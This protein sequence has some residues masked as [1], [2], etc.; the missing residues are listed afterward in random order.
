MKRFS[1]ITL[2]TCRTTAPARV[3]LFAMGSLLALL[4]VDLF[5]EPTLTLTTPELTT[6]HFHSPEYDGYAD[7]IVIEALRRIGYKL[8]VV[9]LPPERSLMMAADGTFDGELIRTP[10]IEIKYPDL[11]RIP[12]PITS[13]E[14]VVYSYHPI[15]LSEGWAALKGKSVAMVIGMKVIE[16]NIPKDAKVTGV[17]SVKQLFTMVENRR[18][19]YSVYVRDIGEDFIKTNQIKGISASKQSIGRIDSYIYLNNKNRGLVPSLTLALESMKKD[20]T[21]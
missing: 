6:A 5:A 20:G 2:P 17:V 21:F 11:I 19:D 12:V 10:A 9:V 1:E 4:S 8:K 16:Q 18:V 13:S 3:F 15:D 14:F 7:K